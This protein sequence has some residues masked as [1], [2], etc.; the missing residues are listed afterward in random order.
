MFEQALAL[1]HDH[2]VNEYPI[3]VDEPGIGERLHKCRTAKR[4]NVATIASFQR[5][6]LLFD[7]GAGERC[8]RIERAPLET[9][10]WTSAGYNNF[11]SGIDLF[12]YAQGDVRYLGPF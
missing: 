5:F 2:R 8:R 4:N 9:V 6:D 7:V 1:I 3:F 10:A 11:S 12:A